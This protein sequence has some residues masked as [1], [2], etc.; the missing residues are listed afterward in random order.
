M[1]RTMLFLPGNSPRMVING[2]FLGCDRIILDLEDAVAPGEKDT[3]RNLVRHALEALDFGKE[4]IVRI[5]GLD[6]AY[7][8]ADVES[9]VPAGVPIILVPKATDAEMI[10]TL[11]DKITRVE[12]ASGR[13]V[14]STKIIALIETALGL[15]NAYA[16]AAASKRNEG[17]F[18]GAED[19]TADL[20]CARTKE[21]R[22][23]EYARS[24]VVACARAAGI[25]AYD[26]PFTDTN[27]IEGARADAALARSMGFSGKALISPKHIDVVNEEFSPTEAEIAYAQ[28]VI[29]VVEEGKRLGKGAV[30][31]K[32]KMIDAPVLARALSVL[33]AAKELEGIV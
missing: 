5:N 29:D 30:S 25:E 1:R 21:G 4:V 32:G 24:R 23:I 13:E 20:R 17:L 31:L 11:D 8:E 19:L 7:W 15:E 9:V 14:G 22:E 3:A 6:T 2:P 28:A 33:A 16:I 10:R 27:D 12:Q 26:T 18:L